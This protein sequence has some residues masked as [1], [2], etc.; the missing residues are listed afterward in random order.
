[1]HQSQ[2]YINSTRRGHGR[3]KSHLPEQQLRSHR[4]Q[5]LSRLSL[6]EPNALQVRAIR[7]NRD[8]QMSHSQWH[9]C[10]SVQFPRAHETAFMGSRLGCQ[11]SS[12][13][14]ITHEIC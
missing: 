7:F 3:Q 9:L 5:G 8:T 6:P 4:R 1:M 13:T 2:M 11:G 12:H 14:Q 10:A